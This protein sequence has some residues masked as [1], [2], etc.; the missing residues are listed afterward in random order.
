MTSVFMERENLDTENTQGELHVK[1]KAD[2]GELLLRGRKYQRLPTTTR[3]QASG[4]KFFPQ[5]SEG[6]SPTDNLIL[7]F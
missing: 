6:T 5:T 7:D 2:I 3:N 4:M 1:V